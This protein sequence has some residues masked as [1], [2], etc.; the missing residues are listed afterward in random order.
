VC[1][2]SIQFM[3][4]ESLLKHVTAKRAADKRGLKT[5][6]SGEVFLFGA[7][8]KLGATVATYPLLVVKSRLQAKQEIG[9]DKSSQYTGTL[10]A[11]VKMVQYEGLAGFYKGMSTKIVQSVMAA[12][13]LFMIK[14]ELVKSATIL[15]ARRK[16]IGQAAS[17]KV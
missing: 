7:I 13:V 12:A 3:I 9:R 6:S 17:L 10:D 15:V 5:V 14:E 1:N 4:Y 2:P 16:K 11:I 8:A